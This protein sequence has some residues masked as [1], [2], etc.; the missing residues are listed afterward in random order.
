MA[1]L[2][3]Q[4][5]M[6]Y[7]PT[8]PRIAQILRTWI[9]YPA[10]GALCL[11][12][13]CG[14][15]KTLMALTEDNCTTYGIEIDADRAVEAKKR[16]HHTLI[17]PFERSIISNKVFGF[18]FLNPP[19][20]VVAGGG[21]RYE[22]VFLTKATRHLIN[23]GV[24]QCIV[25]MA[26]FESARAQIVLRHLFENYLDVQI[27][28]YPDPEYSEFRQLVIIAQRRETT[29]IDPDYEQTVLTRILNCDLPILKAQ[30]HP[31]YDIPSG[32]ASSVRVFRMDHYDFDLA[33]LESCT[34]RLLAEAGI[35]NQEL[36][37]NL[38]AP[39]FLDKAQLALLAVGG[40][41]NGRMPGHYL[42]GTYEN[43]EIET[44][45]IDPD[46][47]VETQVTSKVSSTVFHLLTALT[48]ED[49]SRFYEVR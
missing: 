25:P 23:G 16:L 33:R 2:T 43:R 41:V 44:R 11:D 34:P 48:G 31:R 47:A 18:V 28:I 7:F 40:Y 45:E 27:L 29:A 19:Y 14:E 22:E 8:Q 20:D 17:G 26:L 24:L 9:K 35:K 5:D 21:A 42:L 49:E 6:Q 3:A 37:N 38:V 15:G 39:F 10:K 13:C 12:P 4:A 32:L 36:K 1:R 46:T 30:D